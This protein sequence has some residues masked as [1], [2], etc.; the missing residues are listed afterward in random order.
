M[1]HLRSGPVIAVDLNHG[2]LAVCVLDPSGNPIGAPV[3]VPLEL[4]GLR[5]L[6]GTAESDRPSPVCSPL[7]AHMA[8]GRS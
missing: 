8:P 1:E 4:T 7:R 3:S 5:H 2:H 6:P